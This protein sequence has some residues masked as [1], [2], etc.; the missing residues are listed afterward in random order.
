MQLASANRHS[1]LTWLPCEWHPSR[2]AATPAAH[3]A[4]RC[5]TSLRGMC[6]NAC[7]ALHRKLRGDRENIHVELKAVVTAGMYMCHYTNTEEQMCTCSC[8]HER[9]C[10]PCSWP[11]PPAM[12][13]R[14]SSSPNSAPK[15]TCTTVH[16]FRHVPARMRIR[17]T[18]THTHTR[19]R[20]HSDG[21][22]HRDRSIQLLQIAPCT[23]VCTPGAPSHRLFWPFQLVTAGSVGPRIS[24][25]RS[26][27][28][29]D[30][31]SRPAEY[32]YANTTIQER[33]QRKAVVTALVNVLSARMVHAC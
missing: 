5:A 6:R 16:E 17:W 11:L 30:H 9:I 3:S 21:G 24:Q 12:V 22:C 25:V 20:T 4:Y 13:E 2:P 15:S 27:A 33:M 19:T 8:M 18:H 32:T 28:C 10:R 7:R 23:C 31:K 1:S 14:A 26:N 29:A